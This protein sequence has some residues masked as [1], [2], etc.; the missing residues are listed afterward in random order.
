MMDSDKTH[1]DKTFL[2]LGIYSKNER[3]RRYL[4]FEVRNSKNFE[5]FDLA[6]LTDSVRTHRNKTF[7]LLDIS[8]KTERFAR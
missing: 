8:S 4:E 6:F 1:R 2:L 7:L 3:F 5:I